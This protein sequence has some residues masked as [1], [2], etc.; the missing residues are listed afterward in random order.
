MQPPQLIQHKLDNLNGSM[1]FKEC[2]GP[3]DFTG[4]LYQTFKEKLT[5]I[6]CDFPLRK[7]R[8]E[9]FPVHLMKLILPWYQTQTK[10]VSKKGQ[11]F[12]KHTQEYL[13][14]ILASKIKKQQTTTSLPKGVDYR[15]GRLVPYLKFNQ[16]NSPY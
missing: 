16:C 9:Y 3:D 6:L 1:P 14:K 15:D 12:Y 11:I 10:I 5:P 8:R 4:E 13:D 7:S 2:P